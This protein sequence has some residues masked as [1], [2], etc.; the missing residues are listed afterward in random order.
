MK[1]S[2]KGDYAIKIILDL[3]LLFTKSKQALTQIKDIA[4]RQDIP[5]KFLEQIVST[6]K[7]ANYIR[8]I[9]GPHGGVALIVPPSKITL[10]EIIRLI[11]GT[12]APIACASC[13]QHTICSFEDR[14]VIREV[15]EQ[16]REK[17]N[18]IVD[19]TTFADL[20]ERQNNLEAEQFQGFGI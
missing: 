12:T 16:V 14:C 13:T 9:R 8:T 1:I 5:E 15:F 19:H 4:R 17:T 20:V 2:F 18:E 7:Q 3:S 11:D 6:L 10:G